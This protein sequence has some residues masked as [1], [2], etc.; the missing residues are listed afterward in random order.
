[1]GQATRRVGQR[2]STA[3]SGVGI[4]FLTNAFPYSPGEEFLE[5]EI[6]YWAASGCHCFILP[7]NKTESIRAVDP[8]ITVLDPEDYRK[9]RESLVG[10]IIRKATVLWILGKERNPFSLATR[11][12]ASAVAKR[13]WQILAAIE[14][15]GLDTVLI[16]SYWFN[17]SAYAAA[18]IARRNSGMHVVT[19]AHR[20]DLYEATRIDGFFPLREGLIEAFDLVAPVSRD[21]VEYLK[22]RYPK[23][24]DK[25][26]CFALGVSSGNG[27]TCPA[28]KGR[29]S[30]LSCSYLVPVKRIDKIIEALRQFALSGGEAEW[31]HIGDGPMRAEL[32]ALAGSAL[33]GLGF[34]F[35]FLGQVSNEGV[36]DFYRR[37]AVDV[38]VNAS[39]SEGIPV[40]IMEALSFGVPIIA[41]DVGGVGE[42]VLDGENGRLLPE[43]FDPSELCATFFD[44]E[45]F[46]DERTR[47]AAKRIFMERFDARRNYST[48]IERLRCIA[49]GRTL[50]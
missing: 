38:F 10:K 4:L 31:T 7:V 14:R 21:G 39:D 13:Y 19:R 37:N 22:E 33:S 42:A 15:N 3:Y 48:F 2:E 18:L 17:R 35:H 30:L 40:S 20:Y 27:G 26:E 50:S 25:I 28:A 32:E 23:A 11:G 43:G 12:E 8:A 16:Y 36:R 24:A 9:A 5:E 47:S 6:K 46:R 45:F 41:P 44:E 49:N 29:L 1:M 34:Q